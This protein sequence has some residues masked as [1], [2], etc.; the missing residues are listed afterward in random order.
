MGRN[1]TTAVVGAVPA[2]VIVGGTL[3]AAQATPPE[4]QSAATL[5]AI[6]PG[7]GPRMRVITDNDYSGDPDGV[8]Q[9]AHLLLSPSV[10]VRAVIGS[11]LA[12]GDP[13]D[14]SDQT[15]D[16]AVAKANEVI[17]LAGRSDTSTAVAG[18]NVALEDTTTPDDSAGAQAIIDEALRADTTDPLYVVLGGGLTDLASAYLERPRSPTV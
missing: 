12:P 14:S 5:A 16:N 6:E 3:S 7:P 1:R 2:A 17:A 15:A 10:D 4:T 18:S 9:L 13:F 11:H 8:V